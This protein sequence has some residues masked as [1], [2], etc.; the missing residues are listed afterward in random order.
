[1]RAGQFGFDLAWDPLQ[2]GIEP[3]AN[4]TEGWNG[5]R[6][7]RQ[8]EAAGAEAVQRTDLSFE[9]GN[10]FGAWN[11][12]VVEPAGEKE[13]SVIGVESDRVR[14]DARGEIL[15]LVHHA[16]SQERILHLSA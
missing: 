11:P 6:E 2:L 14:L 5:G 15:N 3:P 7:Q 10:R 13:E 16:A 9:V 4:F 12:P 8:T 1:M